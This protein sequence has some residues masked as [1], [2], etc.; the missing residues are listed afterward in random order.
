MTS[1][2]HRPQRRVDLPGEPE[3]AVRVVLEDGHAVLGADVEH[4]A[5]PLDGQRDA[6]RVVEVRDR[7]EEL[8][9]DAARRERPQRLAQQLRHQAVGVHRDVHDP[10]L[11][12]GEAAQGAHVGRPLGEDDVARVAEDAGDE[13]QRHLRADGDHHVVRVGADP[14]E[15]HDLADLLAQRGNALRG[16]VL[17]RDLA[18]AGDELGDLAGE[19]VE[20][21]RGEVRHAAGERDHLGPA[22]HREQ[23]PDL[24]RRHAR[25]ARRE[26]LHRPGLDGGA[27]GPE[28]LRDGHAAPS[29]VGRGPDR[30][31][32]C[33][34]GV[35]NAPERTT[36]GRTAASATVRV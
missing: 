12:G 34:P 29:V 10:R 18:V 16:A 3:Q 25:R 5:P 17:Q 30:S 13:V 33:A 23:R 6:G 32:S 4:L 14:L 7:V 24:R 2:V 28:R 20:R 19:G 9:D 22:R 21:Q 11:V 36:A 1:G 26:P 31:A 27:G 15:R 35:P 8:R